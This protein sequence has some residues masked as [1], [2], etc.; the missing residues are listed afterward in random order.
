MIYVTQGSNQVVLPAA[1][2][3]NFNPA[4]MSSAR[5][6]V[7]GNVIRQESVLHASSAEATY[8]REI[9]T[10]QRDALLAMYSSSSSVT[11][12][13]RNVGYSAVFRP[14]FATLDGGKILAEIKF[15]VVRRIQ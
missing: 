5:V 3:F 8:S 4:R 11:V 2:G 7:A 13:Y 6:A 9:T 14:S 10:D 1:D 12:H 15:S